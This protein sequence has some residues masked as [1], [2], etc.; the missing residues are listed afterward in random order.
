MLVSN[1]NYNS[2]DRYEEEEILIENEIETIKTDKED[3]TKFKEHKQIVIET[4]EGVDSLAAQTIKEELENKLGCK[5]KVIHHQDQQGTQEHY[6]L[7]ILSNDKI[8]NQKIYKV[9]NDYINKGEVMTTVRVFD[10]SKKNQYELTQEQQETLKKLNE[11][12]FSFIKKDSKTHTV[13]S[14]EGYKKEGSKNSTGLGKLDR[15][16]YILN[17]VSNEKAKL[18]S[19]FGIGLIVDNEIEINKEKVIETLKEVIEKDLEIELSEDFDKYLNLDIEQNE[20]EVSINFNNLIVL[21]NGK[22]GSLS[23]NLLEEQLSKILN[24][25]LENEVI[26]ENEDRLKPKEKV[27]EEINYKNNDT[28]EEVKTKTLKQFKETKEQNEENKIDDKHINFYN[29]LKQLNNEDFEKEIEKLIEA[30]IKID[31][32]KDILGTEIVETKLKEIKEKLE[33][34]EI[35]KKEKEDKEELNKKITELSETK[36]DLEERLKQEQE[37]KNKVIENN[38]N[39]EKELTKEKEEK[40]NIINILEETK[41]D[42]T[43]EKDN[44]NKLS[45]EKTELEE[46]LKQEQEE[47]ERITKEYEDFKEKSKIAYKLLEQE[48][49][50][51][52]EKYKEERE[53]NRTLQKE[54]E[55]K[56]SIIEKLNN[57]IKEQT[58]IIKE[59]TNE[60][61][62]KVKENETLKD[63]IK[64]LENVKTNLEK[65]VKEK[66]ETIKEQSEKIT[67]TLKENETLKKV[68]NELEN[69]VNSFV[70]KLKEARDY[71]TSKEEENEK[72]A[73]TLKQA[74]EYTTELE[75]EIEELEKKVEEQNSKKGKKRTLPNTP[76]KPE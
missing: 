75:S 58:N 1:L 36:K 30:E 64:N 56:D 31:E 39:L 44:N 46:R 22:I 74:S 10:N 63:N 40:E 21:K 14:L 7:H 59:K 5:V 53:I 6:H 42:L 60:L 26:I 32:I 35:I 8:N 34:I 57:T 69:K 33:V 2:Q 54:I 4:N 62:L 23:K 24:N 61:L 17:G 68:K 25:S 66:S 73:K 18:L 76:K 52:Y 3:Y 72:L 15:P 27:L 37:E 65:I 28:K 67:Q 47:K 12:S 16:T 48:K 55:N 41:E 13:E 51:L 9:V 43:K 50:E 20:N 71:I 38:I 19:R 11:D 29:E 45:K 49:Q 70:E